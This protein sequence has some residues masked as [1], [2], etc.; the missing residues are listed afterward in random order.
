MSDKKKQKHENMPSK[1]EFG[2]P[3]TFSVDTPSSGND[4]SV[5]YQDGGSSSGEPYV[6]D[7]GGAVDG[8]DCSIGNIFVLNLA[9][10]PTETGDQL[11]DRIRNDGVE[12]FD[13]VDNEWWIDSSSSSR[14]PGYLGSNGADR[15]NSLCAVAYFPE[16][17]GGPCAA[18][19]R[20]LIAPFDWNAQAI[21]GCPQS[22]R[23]RRR[24]EA[25]EAQSADRKEKRCGCRKLS[26]GLIIS[27]NPLAACDGWLHYSLQMRQGEPSQFQL[28]LPNGCCAKSL[29]ANQIAVAATHVQWRPS[30]TRPLVI[31]Q[32]QGLLDTNSSETINGRK[33]D[34]RFPGL[35]K[36]G[37]VIH[38]NGVAH[39][40]VVT[41]QCRQAAQPVS[42]DVSKD[43]FVQVNDNMHS[44]RDNEGI[45]DL[46]VKL[47]S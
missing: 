30:P 2:S 45:I 23:T 32:P 31:Q 36:F 19:D 10:Q 4:S 9:T 26:S 5:N 3:A 35:P 42:L 6:C 29:R 18:N 37:L 25:A 17:S 47:V 21:D 15:T 39:K 38:Q 13:I 7:V 41:S 22:A 16:S 46:W 12:C 40:T 11:A 27:V 20:I 33:C 24:L 43:I 8:A 14:V 1:R 28:N 44:L 34:M